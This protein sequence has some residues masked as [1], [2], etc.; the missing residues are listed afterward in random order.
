MGYMIVNYRFTLNLLLTPYIQKL[1]DGAILFECRTVLVG[2]SGS[3]CGKG[4]G[5]CVRLVSIGGLTA[6][7]DSNLFKMSK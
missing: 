5:D 7:S 1:C 4:G 6:V 2:S 3:R